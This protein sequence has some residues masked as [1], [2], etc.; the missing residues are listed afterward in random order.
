MIT[1]NRSRKRGTYTAPG[2]VGIGQRAEC[3]N[4]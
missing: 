1:R 3:S 4:R 2:L